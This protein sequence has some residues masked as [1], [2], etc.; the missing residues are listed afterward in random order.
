[1]S[2]VEK[3]EEKFDFILGPIAAVCRPIKAAIDWYDK[4]WNPLQTDPSMRRLYRLANNY[5]GAPTYEEALKEDY[6]L[7]REGKLDYGVG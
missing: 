7:K 2:L 6:R 3:I 5:P 1:M 4:E